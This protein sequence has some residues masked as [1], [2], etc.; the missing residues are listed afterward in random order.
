MHQCHAHDH[1][2]FKT[3]GWLLPFEKL[4]TKVFKGQ[5]KGVVNQA[6]TI[7]RGKQLSKALD[8]GYGKSLANVDYDTPDFEML[9]QLQANVWSF[10]CSADYQQ[11]KDLN[12]ALV[13]AN[14]KQRSFSEFKAE[15]QKIGEVY[16]KQ[17][18]E[19]EYNHAVATSQM[20]TR[21]VEFQQNEDIAPNL[22]YTTVGDDRVR[23]AHRALNGIIR[24]IK[25]SFWDVYYPPNDWG[26]RC[27]V[28]QVDGKETDISKKALPTLPAMFK[29]NLAKDGVLYPDGHPYFATEEKADRK[30]IAD[31]AKNLYA[32]FTRAFVRQQSKKDYKEDKYFKVSKLNAPVRV[33]YSEIKNITGKPHQNAALRNMVANNIE[34]VLQL[35]KPVKTAKDTKPEHN[36]KYSEWA[37]YLYEFG[38]DKF[39]INLGKLSK[40]NLYELHAITD[41]IK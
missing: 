1:V 33:G 8:E 17:R 28:Q 39:Y 10:S 11:L 37:Y 35:A 5:Q 14:G 22:K 31:V 26:C 24:P 25:D 41:K 18:L 19:V 2:Q 9:R 30:A 27:D 13:D 3:D 4:V 15:A 29:T 36:G 40:G 21:W 6:T 38:E 23:Q 12:A 32:K 34:G 16:N 20:A 7:W